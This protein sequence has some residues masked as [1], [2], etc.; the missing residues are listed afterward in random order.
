MVVGIDASGIIVEAGDE[1]QSKYNLRPGMYVCG[2]TRVG[3]E[4]YAAGQE[5]HLMDAQVAIPKPKNITTLQAATIGAGIETAA[6]SVFEGL[7]VDLPNP[8]HVNQKDE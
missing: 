6:V 3:V 2:C 5:Y 4:E 1:A 7:H 8:E